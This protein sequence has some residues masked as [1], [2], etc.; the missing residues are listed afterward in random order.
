MRRHTIH[1]CNDLEGLARANQEVTTLLNSYKLA[2][3]LVHDVSLGLEEVVSNILKYGYNDDTQ[4]QIEIMIALSAAE[5]SVTVVDDG[6]E[7]DPLQQPEP[8][9]TRPIES[10]E[11]GG[12]G[13]YFLSKLFDAL[14]YR[15]E[16]GKNFLIL[17]KRLPG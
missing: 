7:F 12:L 17:R 14:E 16:G 1:L 2:P 6:H 5:L 15:R 13:I 11:P 8:D 9:R 10:R 3:Q 4:H